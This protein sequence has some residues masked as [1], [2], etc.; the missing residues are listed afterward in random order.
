MGDRL[1]QSD[2]VSHAHIWLCSPEYG[3]AHSS[4]TGPRCVCQCVK[5]ARALALVK[6]GPDAHCKHNDGCG[7]RLARASCACVWVAGSDVW[8]AVHTLR[9]AV[10]K[11]SCAADAH[12]RMALRQ[13]IFGCAGIQRRTWRRNA[14]TQTA[15]ALPVSRRAAAVH[16][17]TDVCQHSATW[18]GQVRSGLLLGR[19]L[20][21]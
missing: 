12:S 17:G 5:T 18:S 15:L 1:I 6:A 20:G 9:V 10:I 13:R 8:P 19:S 2:G 7:P 16:S 21:P 14:A 3:A 11:H 4:V